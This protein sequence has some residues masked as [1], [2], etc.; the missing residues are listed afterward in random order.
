L[1]LLFVLLY[2]VYAVLNV[3]DGITTWIILRPDKFHLELNPVARWIFIKLGIPQGIIIT[4][5]AVL[6]ILSPLIFCLA[7]RHM[8]LVKITLG[9]GVAFFSWLVTDNFLI[10]RKQNRQT[11]KN[12]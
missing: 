7:A 12:S 3:F 11:R 1:D 10:I 2:A 9:L 4:E 6:S 8:L 5:M